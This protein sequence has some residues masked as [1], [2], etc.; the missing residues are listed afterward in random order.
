MLDK[1]E[2]TLRNTDKTKTDVYEL[3]GVIKR[4]NYGKSYA[5]FLVSTKTEIRSDFPA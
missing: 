5:E 3:C 2:A 1:N 4:F